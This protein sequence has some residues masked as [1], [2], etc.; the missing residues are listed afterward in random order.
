[1]GGERGGDLARKDPSR[2]Q[3]RTPAPPRFPRGS[4][5]SLLTEAAV[6]W[7]LLGPAVASSATTGSRPPSRPTSYKTA[8]IAAAATTADAEPHEVRA[9]QAASR[10]APPSPPLSPPPLDPL[11]TGGGEHTPDMRN[12]ERGPKGVVWVCDSR[13]APRAPGLKAPEGLAVLSGRSTGLCCCVRGVHSLY[14][15]W[16]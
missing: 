2:P 5:D 7:L 12:A 13:K 8:A 4:A 16:A 6:S 11:L 14:R 15:K 1:M 10:R 3:P 9:V